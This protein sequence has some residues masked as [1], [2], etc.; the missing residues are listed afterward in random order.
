M[1]VG[2][3]FVIWFISRKLHVDR[4]NLVFQLI[5]IYIILLYEQKNRLE[6]HSI[7]MCLAKR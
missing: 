4:K 7:K 2:V 5:R 1:R 3:V 6:L